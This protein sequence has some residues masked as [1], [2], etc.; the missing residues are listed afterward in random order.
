MVNGNYADHVR[1]RVL[2]AAKYITESKGTIRKTAQKFFVSKSTIHN[3]LVK[4]LPVIN[5][6]IAAEV[7]SI[8]AINKAERH[9]RGGLRTKEKYHAMH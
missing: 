8:L 6:E 4:R 1:S 5:P 7:H 3:D 2:E 9:I